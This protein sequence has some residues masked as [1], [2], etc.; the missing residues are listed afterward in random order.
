MKQFQV[1]ESIT[2]FHVKFV[3]NNRFAFGKNEVLYGWKR[4]L[5]YNFSYCIPIRS[6]PRNLFIFPAIFKFIAWLCTLLG[7]NF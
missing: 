6:W 5:L 4:W 1:P 3:G 2:L 7:C